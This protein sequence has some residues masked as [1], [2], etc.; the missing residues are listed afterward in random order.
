[1]YVTKLNGRTDGAHHHNVSD[2]D[3]L[4]MSD[5]AYNAAAMRDEAAPTPSYYRW[6]VPGKATT[7]S[8]SLHV[9]ERLGLA[10]QQAGEAPSPRRP[11]I[12]GFLLGNVKRTRGLTI[13]E[14]EGFEPV[15]C[16]HAFGA[17]YFLSGADQ[18]RLAERLRRHRPVDG[19]SVV[20]FF[21]SNTRR[22]FALAVE[23]VGL[24]ASYFSKPS[25]ILLLVHATAKE[26]LKG[27]FF[28][29]EQRAIRTMRPYLEFPFESGALLTEK[30][31][32]CR[33]AS[34]AP[35][36]SQHASGIERFRVEWL[37][38]IAA[39]AIAALGGVL[40]R[41]SRPANAQAA[42]RAQPNAG[43]YGALHDANGPK[44]AEPVAAA[45]PVEPP[46]GTDGSTTL[47]L[48]APAA[49]PPEAPAPKAMPKARTASRM[50]EIPIAP[51][52]AEVASVPSLPVP[53]SIGVGLP[54][55]TEPLFKETGILAPLL[56]DI[57][58][59]FVTVAVEPLPTGRRGL[60]GRI[61]S[62]RNA[63]KAT[64]FVPPR[65]VQQSSPE[66]PLELRKQ[67]QK[68]AVPVTV[69]LYVGR[70]GAVN[71]A[72]LLSN[73]TGPHRDLAALAVFASRKFHFSPAQEGSETVP[74]EVLVRF[75]FGALASR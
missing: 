73:G 13:V 54:E 29:W 5:K 61:F 47:I 30:H 59:P 68:T 6:E 43:A 9:V 65:L 8:L 44:T 67:I 21:R 56:P 4:S 31:A 10:M 51:Q 60:V 45:V 42:V 69:K 17:S 50:A 75:R 23:D 40:H 38:A 3:M 18:Q 22:E 70:D 37:V 57:P 19:A 2:F 35:A 14:V 15:E 64:A 12:G 36:K 27:G 74:A 55:S 20:G 63:P 34:G 72:E 41:G 7:V 46:P 62:R 1:L 58:D 28:I 32:I 11:E 71:F 39:L 52:P 26:A 53:P 16:E 33:G 49:V 48:P 66:V 24:M 25:M